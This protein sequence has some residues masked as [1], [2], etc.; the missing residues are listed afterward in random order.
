MTKI[1][2]AFALVLCLSGAAQA[3]T[4]TQTPTIPYTGVEGFLYTNSNAQQQA[5]FNMMQAYVN[6][7]TQVQTAA[8]YQSAEKKLRQG[9][10]LTAYEQ[11]ILARGP[12]PI[13]SGNQFFVPIGA[14]AITQ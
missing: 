10:V 8:I 3:Q 13:T 9:E 4:Q 14:T 11:S 2:A 6:F 5:N 1:L 12:M 7:S